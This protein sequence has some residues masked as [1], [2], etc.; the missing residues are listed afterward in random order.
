VLEVERPAAAAAAEVEHDAAGGVA[1]L[2]LGGDCEG[3][4]APVQDVVLHQAAHG[5][6]QR[7]LVAGYGLGPAS[8]MGTTRSKER[9]SSGS[10]LVRVARR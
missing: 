1:D 2:D 9:S 10:T 6:E 5:G 7:L 8:D 4:V 3:A